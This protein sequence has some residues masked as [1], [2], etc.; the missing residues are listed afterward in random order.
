MFGNRMNK[1]RYR[2]ILLMNKSK[3]KHKSSEFNSI[4]VCFFLMF[5]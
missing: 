5:F 2:I 3:E 1:H 4:I